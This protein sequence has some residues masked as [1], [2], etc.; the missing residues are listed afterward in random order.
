MASSFV[1]F[2]QNM[3]SGSGSLAGAAVG[4]TIGFFGQVVGRDSWDSLL[5]VVHDIFF[6]SMI[7]LRWPGIF[8]FFD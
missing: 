8:R 5:L 7:N 3:F 4:M 1:P 6:C 2:V